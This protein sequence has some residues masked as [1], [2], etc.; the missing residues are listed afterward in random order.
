MLDRI[1]GKEI[2]Y[3]VKGHRGLVIFAIIL[4][5]ISALFVVIPAYL[6]QPFVDE[7]MKGGTDP[8]AWKIPWLAVDSGSFFPWQRTELILVK[9]ISPNLL[10]VVL[11][12]IFFLSVIFKSITTYLSGLAA[13]AFSNR[14]IKSLRIRLYEKFISLNQG[15]YNK[16]KSGILISRSTADLTVMQYSIANIII[17][18]DL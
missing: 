16:N 7:G 8:V 3:Y 12:L 4:T 6:L 15:F 5:A 9:K 10:L 14:A 18:L 13:T 2:A 11:T 17:G 1:L